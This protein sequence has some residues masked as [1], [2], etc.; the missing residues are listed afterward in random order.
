METLGICTPWELPN[1]SLPNAEIRVIQ[2]VDEMGNVAYCVK[3]AGYSPLSTFIGLIELA[4]GAII[5]EFND[6]RS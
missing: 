6:R 1:G 3:N 5:E 2:Y 4:K